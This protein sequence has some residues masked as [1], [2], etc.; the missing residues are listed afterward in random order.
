MSVQ[1][2]QKRHGRVQFAILKN[3]LVVEVKIINLETK[4]EIFSLISLGSN[5]HQV[6]L[7]GERENQD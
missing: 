5:T 7:Y 1:G 4:K 6:T 3:I 2:T